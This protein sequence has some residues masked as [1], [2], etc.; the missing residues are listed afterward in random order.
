MPEGFRP[1]SALLREPTPA[2]EPPDAAEAEDEEV[3]RAQSDALRE[4]RLFRAAIVQRAGVCV[5]TLLREIAADVLGRELRAA[6]A[7]IDAIVQNAIARCIA[8]EPLRVRVHPADA[9]KL[10]CGIPAAA[11]DTL[12]QGDAVVEVRD[13]EIDLSLGVRLA[14]VL[15]GFRA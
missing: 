10:G 9:H 6:P 2:C 1:L 7:Q 3:L 14:A 13:G 5:E 15:R 11:D 4:A 8:E 12:Y